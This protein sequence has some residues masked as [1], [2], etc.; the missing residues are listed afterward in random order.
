ML[1]RLGSEKLVNETLT[2]RRIPHVMTI[3]QFVLGM[4]LAIYMGFARLNTI[5]VLWPRTRL[6]TGILKV[7]RLPG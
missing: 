5:F 2:V 7:I 3:Y 6:L 1:K 4:V